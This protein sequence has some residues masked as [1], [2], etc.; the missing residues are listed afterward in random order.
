MRKAYLQSQEGWAP[1]PGGPPPLGGDR[2]EEPDGLSESG[3]W[4]SYF[5]LIKKGEKNISEANC[6]ILK[7]C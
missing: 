2:G 6:K 7:I 4:L 3:L 5:F 1:T